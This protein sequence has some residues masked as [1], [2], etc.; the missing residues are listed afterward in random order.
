MESLIPET[1]KDLKAQLAKTDTQLWQQEL[2]KEYKILN[3]KK[4]RQSEVSKEFKA[5]QKPHLYFNKVC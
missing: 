1:L 4:L 3:K 2:P 5:L